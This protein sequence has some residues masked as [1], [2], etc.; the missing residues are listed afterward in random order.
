VGQADASLHEDAFFR[1]AGIPFLDFS[2]DMCCGFP[3]TASGDLEAARARR[4]ELLRRI[5]A[6]ARAACGEYGVP[7]A[8]IMSSCPTCQESLRMAQTEAG[9]SKE[10]LVV[11]D[12][13]EYVVKRTADRVQRQG[14]GETI[15]LKVPCHATPQAA[16][17]QMRLLAECGYDPV[18]LDQCCGMAGI[19]RIEHPDVGLMLAERLSGAIRAAC[20]R[21]VVSGCPSC[22]DGLRLQSTLERADLEVTD[23]FCLLR[24]G[25]IDVVAS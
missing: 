3:F 4:S 18:R 10:L 12:P 11:A 21:R 7:R 24:Q 16:S 1:A 20:I 6:A 23:L 5:C 25:S 8:V 17:S 15:G 13:A 2:P 14:P 19:G 22:R 9:G